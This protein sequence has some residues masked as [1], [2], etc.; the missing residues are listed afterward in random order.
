MVPRFG[1]HLV[2]TPGLTLGILLHELLLLTLQ[3]VYDATFHAHHGLLPH[4]P[5]LSPIEHVH[6]VSVGQVLIV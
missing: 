4:C 5:V 1:S 3:S 2:L 6:S